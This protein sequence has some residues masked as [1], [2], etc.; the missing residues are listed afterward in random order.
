V[1]LE[2]WFHIFKN[3][4]PAQIVFPEQGEKDAEK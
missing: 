3:F 1:F 4:T 2:I